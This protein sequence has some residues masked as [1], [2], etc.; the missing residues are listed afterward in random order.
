MAHQRED[1]PSLVGGGTGSVSAGSS[2]PYKPE[3]DPPTGTEGGADPAGQAPRKGDL[4][5]EGLAQGP[6]AGTGA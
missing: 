2:A 4:D 5:S 3:A 6:H 1:H